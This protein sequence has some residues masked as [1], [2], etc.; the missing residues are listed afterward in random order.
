MPAYGGPAY[1]VA[2]LATALAEV[3]VDV[4]L[5]SSDRS[6]PPAAPVPAGAR[7]RRLSGDESEA[8]NEFGGADIIHD[9]GIWLPHNHRLANIARSLHIP[10][11][12][13]LR[14]ML[15]PWA[16]KHRFWKKRLAWQLYQRRDLKRAARHHATAESEAE[17]IGRFG[18]GVPI[19]VIPNGVDVPEPRPCRINRS[20]RVALYLGRIH[21]IKG[22]PMLIAA[23]ARARPAGWRLT[24]IGPDEEGQRAVVQRAVAA[25]GLDDVVSFKEPVDGDAKR[26]AFYAADVF[27][28]PSHSESFGVVVAEALAHGLPVLATTGAPWSMLPSKGCGWWVDASVDGLAGGLAEAT[29][30]DADALAAMGARGRAWVSAQFGWDRVAR[31]FAAAYENVLA[32]ER[33]PVR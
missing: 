20:E 24:I 9:N 33:Q 12:V 30:K 31:Q 8:L 4:G 1:S 13:S 23:W 29:A 22:L 26:S 3:G 14:G 7:V 28:L 21:P 18:L 5:W 15:E 32:R 16:I 17:N 10:R 25:A 19:S 27:I 2:R 6:T 11:I